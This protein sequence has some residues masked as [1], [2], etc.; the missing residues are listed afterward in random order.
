MKLPLSDLSVWV[1]TD[2]L[3]WGLFFFCTCAI[4]ISFSYAGLCWYRTAIS[5]SPIRW[6]KKI[7]KKNVLVNSL[8]RYQWLFLVFKLWVQTHTAFTYVGLLEKPIMVCSLRWGVLCPWCVQHYVCVCAHVCVP[9]AGGPARSRVLPDPLIEASFTPANDGRPQLP[10]SA[11][12][13]G[14][15]QKFISELNLASCLPSMSLLGE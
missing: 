8:S 11:D 4:I 14:L 7:N 10:Q 13:T 2:F 15:Q 5:Q 12:S 1:A 9:P 6:D 3:V